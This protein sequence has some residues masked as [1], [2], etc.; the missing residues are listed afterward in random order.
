MPLK[1]SN[2]LTYS[3]NKTHLGTFHAIYR[4]H[5]ITDSVTWYIAEVFQMKGNQ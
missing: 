1:K 5:Q 4:I 2:Q 3:T